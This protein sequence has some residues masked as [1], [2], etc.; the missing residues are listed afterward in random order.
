MP[1]AKMCVLTVAQEGQSEA[2]AA[3]YDGQHIPDLLKVPGLV[4]AKRYDV[5]TLKL[6][7]GM[8][9]F[10]SFA[11]YSLEGDDI[12]A[13]LKESAVRMGTPDMPTSDALDSS[14]TFAFLATEVT[15]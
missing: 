6:P 12:A 10:E 5:K 14:K 13:I 2:M 3:W 8:E 9:A 15:G 4:E 1:K 11:V 7:P